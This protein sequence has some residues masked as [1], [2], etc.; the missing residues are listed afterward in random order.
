LDKYSKSIV[1]QTNPSE[2]T[3][4]AQKGGSL[5]RQDDTYDK[6]Y[7]KDKECFT[8]HK[9]GHPSTHCRASKANDKDNKTVLSKTS[10]A[11]KSSK[12]SKTSDINKAQ[13]R[14]KKS[15]ATLSTKIDEVDNKLN[16]SDSK[17]DEEGDSHFQTGTQTGY[18]M[19]QHK[20]TL[21]QL[22]GKQNADVLFKL[23]G[24]KNTIDL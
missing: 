14:L 3:T 23:G 13:K 22:F 2:G 4:F 12:A 9:K 10:K 8:C 21:Q 5:K 17:S 1:V 15:F 24:S 16:L 11:S 7:W 18:Q 19:M 6:K 20:T